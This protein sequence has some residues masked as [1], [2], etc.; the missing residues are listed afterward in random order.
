MIKKT[1]SLFQKK[2]QLCTFPYYFPFF[3]ALTKIFEKHSK[4][5]KLIFK[6]CMEMVQIFCSG[7]IHFFR[8]LNACLSSPF[9]S[10]NTKLWSLLKSDVFLL[11]IMTLLMVDTMYG[12]LALVPHNMKSDH[13]EL[14]LL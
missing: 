5:L 4:S 13:D 12:T 3:S 1:E 6:K 9:Q 11:K 10:I 7:F 8:Y 14:R 2:Q